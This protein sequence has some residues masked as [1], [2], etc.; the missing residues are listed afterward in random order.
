MAQMEPRGLEDPLLAC[1]VKFDIPLHHL[2]CSSGR[3]TSNGPM[4]QLKWSSEVPQIRHCHAASL[5][6]VK[7]STSGLQPAV[8]LLFAV[9][10][11]TIALRS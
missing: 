3:K 2:K 4:S 6:A 1:K 5:F 10:G 7:L 11:P 8:S 9:V